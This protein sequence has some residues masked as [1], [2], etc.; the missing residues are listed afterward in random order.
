MVSWSLFIVS[1][2]RDIYTTNHRGVKRL[3][4]LSQCLPIIP[5]NSSAN[6]H[7]LFSKY[8]LNFFKMGHGY[9]FKGPVILNFFALKAE[10]CLIDPVGFKSLIGR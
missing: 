6:D 3:K 1:F 4:Q 10:K 9:V 2:I 7:R 5:K 8:N